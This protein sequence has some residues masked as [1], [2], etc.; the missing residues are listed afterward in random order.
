MKQEILLKKNFKIFWIVP[1]SSIIQA[2]KICVS[3]NNSASH[4]S[5]TNSAKFTENVIELLK[6][7]LLWV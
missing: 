3:E 5:Y 4:R 1:N 7:I 2:Q 6:I